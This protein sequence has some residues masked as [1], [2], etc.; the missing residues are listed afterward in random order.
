MPARVKVSQRILGRHAHDDWYVREQLV[1]TGYVTAEEAR[2]AGY[3]VKE[4][5]G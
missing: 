5:R 2:T 3:G 4:G 1:D